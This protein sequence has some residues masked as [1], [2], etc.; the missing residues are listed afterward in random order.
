MTEEKEESPEGIEDLRD[1]YQVPLVLCF[2]DLGYQR[3]TDKKRA[4]RIAQNLNPNRLMVVTL[5]ERADGNMA[6][7]DGGHR[8][9]ALRLLGYD[10][11]W[12]HVL[13]GL[14]PQEE[15][16]LFV[17]L[18]GG[19]IHKGKIEDLEVDES[20][21][22]K[23]NP[24]Q[25]YVAQKAGDDTLANTVHSMLE[26]HG[27]RPAHGGKDP[28]SISS[29]ALLKKI[30]KRS[31]EIFEKVLEDLAEM[32]PDEKVI[33]TSIQ[34]IFTIRARGVI[35]PTDEE[36]RVPSELIKKLRSFQVSKINSASK[37]ISCS[38]GSRGGGPQAES[39]LS[40]LNYGKHKRKRW[41]LGPDRQKL[42]KQ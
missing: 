28:K 29:I 10:N 23:V 40:L 31:P 42:L 14:T 1:I 7:I 37:P 32:I 15:A 39:L 25:V 26:K 19:N 41:I 35:T 11:V 38:Y 17:L 13:H 22:I 5:S 27:F 6:I 3:P 8:V 4:A 18:D 12:A 21:I 36:P 30:V 16:R 9:A 34:A 20:E 33:T 2:K 24:Y